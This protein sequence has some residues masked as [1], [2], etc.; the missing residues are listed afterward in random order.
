MTGDHRRVRGEDALGRHRLERR[1]ERQPAREVLAQQLE[2]QERRVTLV[3]V[4]HGRC[5]SQRAQYAYAADA[6]DHLLAHA[7]RVIAPIQP[8]RDVAVGRGVL[9]AV[10]IEQVHRRASRLCLPGARHDVAPRD[11]HAHLEPLTLGGAQRLDRQ[12]ARIT[13][14]ILGMLDAVVVDRLAEVALLVEQAHGEEARVLIGCRLAVV[15]GQHAESTRVDR[16]ALMKAVLGAEIRGQRL[17]G[18]GRAR[19]HVTIE[20]LECAS[21]ALEIRTIVSAALESRLVDTAQHQARVA[22]GLLPQ[23]GIEVLEQRAGRTM[24]AEEQVPGEL[25]ETRQALRDDRG[26]FEERASHRRR[27]LTV[28]CIPSFRQNQAAW[29]MAHVQ[30]EVSQ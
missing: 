5:Q 14:T 8:M 3:E 27:S 18:A 24:P 7:R 11:A 23:R 9:R 12:I 15:G 26:D 30:G 19:V 20:G 29:D 17:C 21:V 22:V 16:K 1:A 6:E 28:R 4:P 25:G 10:G 2:D 13:L